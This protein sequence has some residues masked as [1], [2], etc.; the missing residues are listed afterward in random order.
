[1]VLLCK[2]NN[3]SVIKEDI[4]ENRFMHVGDFNRLGAKISTQWNK[5]KVTWEY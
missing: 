3:Q 4:F 2:A 1:M 5:A